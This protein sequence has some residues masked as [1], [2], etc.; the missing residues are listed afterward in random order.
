MSYQE[1]LL[2][3]ATALIKKS[4]YDEIGG[5]T[6]D[7]GVGYEDYEFF[8]RALQSGG[9]IRIH[10]EPLY[11]YEVGRPSM[12]SNTSTFRNFNRVISKINPSLHPEACM[13]FIQL[14]V[15]KKALIQQTKSVEYSISQADF[16]D[17]CL[18]IQ[19][20]E[21]P[22][23]DETRKQLV[24]YSIKLGAFSAAKAFGESLNII[25]NR[26]AEFDVKQYMYFRALQEQKNYKVLFNNLSAFSK[27]REVNFIKVLKIFKGILAD[28]EYNKQLTLENFELL[29]LNVSDYYEGLPLIVSTAK[30]IGLK[31]QYE[32][33]LANLTSRGELEYLKE[34][35]DV[36]GAVKK[37]LFKS[38]FEHYKKYGQSEGRV[39]FT[40]I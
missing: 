19:R 24:K 18:P 22:Q 38:G 4:F 7:K 10:P 27:I 13:D 25:S 40:N 1:N 11:L 34:H 23:H 28:N 9:E 5:Y 12:V 33:Y 16:S 6:E 36:A 32:R 35:S 39:G 2:G 37:G 26:I 14:T 30:V 17:I 8:F 3:A 15:G 20:G 29:L 31:D 21:F